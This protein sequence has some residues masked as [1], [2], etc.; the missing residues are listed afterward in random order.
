MSYWI[1]VG[2]FLFQTG[3]LCAETLLEFVQTFENQIQILF[4]KI[5][6]IF[7]FKT[8][9]KVFLKK[10][11]FTLSLLIQEK[12]FKIHVLSYVTLSKVLKY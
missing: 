5:N 6:C 12:R 11:I 2:N 4:K 7:D 10:N 1:C 3:E 8:Y 9:Q